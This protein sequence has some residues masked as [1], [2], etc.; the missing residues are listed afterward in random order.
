[1]EAE[2]ER[3]LDEVP[4]GLKA[5][6]AKIRRRL[7]ED[8]PGMR[9][10]FFNRSVAD[11]RVEISGP[12]MVIRSTTK[13]PEMTCDCV[14]WHPE[15][16][17]AGRA[18]VRLSPGQEVV[19][20]FTVVRG[21]ALNLGFHSGETSLFEETITLPDA[22]ERLALGVGSSGSQSETVAADQV[23]GALATAESG[24]ELWWQGPTAVEQSEMSD[25]AAEQLRALGYID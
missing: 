2:G 8:L 12:Q 5:M 10:R 4:E 15:A 7:S 18:T 22:T 11:L 17:E 23:P 13:S 21:T 24:V 3:L 16:G 20:I 19:L 25:E 6:A 1:M 14:E 9:L